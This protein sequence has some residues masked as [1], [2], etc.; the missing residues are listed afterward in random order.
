MEKYVAAELELVTIDEDVI[1]A[2]DQVNS[3]TTTGPVVPVPTVQ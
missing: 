3:T 2:S 1:P